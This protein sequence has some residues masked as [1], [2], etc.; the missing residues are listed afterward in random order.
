MS[1]DAYFNASSRRSVFL[2]KR[3]ALACLIARLDMYFHTCYDFLLTII[4][5]MYNHVAIWT[6]MRMELTFFL[7]HIGIFITSVQRLVL[8]CSMVF[9]CSDLWY[10]THLLPVL[11]WMV[12]WTEDSYDF[13]SWFLFSIYLP[14]FICSSSFKTI[15]MRYANS[16]KFFFLFPIYYLTRI[17]LGMPFHC[18]CTCIWHFFYWSH[19]CK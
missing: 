8:S 3:S 14:Y 7:L 6:N 13:L 10:F 17:P 2:Q 11:L 4:S 12:H 15:L 1:V 5:K 19:S 9:L 18:A 16:C